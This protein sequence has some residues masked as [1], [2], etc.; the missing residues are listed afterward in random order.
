MQTGVDCGLYTLVQPILVQNGLPLKFFGK[1][2]AEKRRSGIEMRRRMTL[3][4][5][6]G[7]TY[8]EPDDGEIRAMTV[9][10]NRLRLEGLK[11]NTPP[12]KRRKRTAD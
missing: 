11:N 3:S 7:T 6:Y 9:A 8:F 10:E 4:L 5:F 12:K 1:S 2:T